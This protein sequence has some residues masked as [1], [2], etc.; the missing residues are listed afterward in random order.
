[1]DVGGSQGEAAGRYGWTPL[2][3]ML[4]GCPHAEFT[5]VWLKDGGPLLLLRAEEINLRMCVAHL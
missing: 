1:M 3:C 5:T 4:N 2:V